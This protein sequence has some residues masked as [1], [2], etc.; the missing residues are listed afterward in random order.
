MAKNKISENAACQKFISALKEDQDRTTDIVFD[1]MNKSKAIVMAHVP[2][3]GVVD[4]ND[5]NDTIEYTNAMQG[6]RAYREIDAKPRDLIAGEME[7]RDQNGR[8]GLFDTQVNEIDPNACSGSCRFRFGQGF[9]TY[10]TRDYEFP[11]TTDVVCARDYIRKGKA[12][13]A[14]YFRGL[15]NSF[16]SYGRD[17]YEANLLNLVIMNG[18]ANATIL[19]ADYF[20]PTAGGWAAPPQNR[21]SIHFLRRYRQYMIREGGV[22]ENGILDISMPR[23]DWRDAVKEDQ[24]RNLGQGGLTTFDVKIFDDTHGQLQGRE[25]HT[26]DGIRCTFD[27]MPVRGYFKPTGTSQS[28]EVFH[29]FVRVYHWKNVPNEDGGL[30]AE[31]NH[32]Y[33][34]TFIVVDGIRHRMNTLAFVINK[35]SF[36]RFGLGAAK[37][38]EGDKPM[39]QNFEVK[40]LDKSYIDCNDYNDKFKIVSRHAFRFKVMKSELSGAIA[41]VHSRASG[42]VNAPNDPIDVSIDPAFASPEEYE[43]CEAGLCDKTNCGCVGLEADNNGDCVAAGTKAKVDL[44]PAVSANVLFLGDAIDVEIEVARK[45]NSNGAGTVDY[46]ITD[47]AA[48]E[49]THFNAA[50]TGTISFGDGEHGSI[51]IP[52]E[53]IS[54]IDENTVADFTITLSN[55]TGALEL[56]SSL[57]TVVSIEDGR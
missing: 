16:R 2:D 17:N 3:G 38:Y 27:E 39:G 21:M 25:Y 19:D 34:A 20:E 47:G 35:K 44:E 48:E 10:S 5:N 55:A 31:P 14:G 15:S 54:A 24:I 50:A 7:G 52:I 30:S 26:Y 13:V 36:R 42:Y 22:N 49:G 45:G 57:T 1:D 11:M 8:T 12:H 18:G 29:D 51:A 33:D 40:V 41:Y 23:E 32:D 37:K 6:H 4:Y 56:G 9:K 53:V 43:K 28:G 46:T